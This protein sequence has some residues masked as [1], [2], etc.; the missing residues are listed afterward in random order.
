MKHFYFCWEEFSDIYSLRMKIIAD[1]GK[2]PNIILHVFLFVEL[3][4]K[5]KNS[6]MNLNKTEKKINSLQNIQTQNESK[7]IAQEIQ[8][9]NSNFSII[10]GE[11]N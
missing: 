1:Y 6:I 4:S 2:K 5:K 10:K 8:I 7:L 3:Y 11:R 9:R